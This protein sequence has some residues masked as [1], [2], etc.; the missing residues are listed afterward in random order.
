MLSASASS[1]SWGHSRSGQ[2]F[3]PSWVAFYLQTIILTS[4]STNCFIEKASFLLGSVRAEIRLL[5]PLLYPQHSEQRLAQI[6]CWKNYL[7]GKPNVRT[8][9]QLRRVGNKY[10]E[11]CF[12]V[13]LWNAFVYGKGFIWMG[14]WTTDIVRPLCSPLESEPDALGSKPPSWKLQ[15]HFPGFTILNGPIIAY[16][17]PA[18]RIYRNNTRDTIYVNIFQGFIANQSWFIAHKKSCVVGGGGRI[19]HIITMLITVH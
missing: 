1:A 18:T 15:E 8:N 19:V 14:L 13:S 6:I 2:T 4:I 16:P 11:H 12:V 7:P 5:C 9:S 10:R 17:P 3:S